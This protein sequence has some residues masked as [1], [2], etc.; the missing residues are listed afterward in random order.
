[1]AD[2]PDL[3]TSGGGLTDFPHLPAADLLHLEQQC[4][5]FESAWQSGSVPRLEDFITSVAPHRRAH[6]LRELLFLEREYRRRRGENPTREEY[7]ARFPGDRAA[8]DEVF[9]TAMPPLAESATRTTG[10]R[11]A[12]DDASAFPPIPGFKIL[13]LL[14]RGG[15]GIVYRAHEESLQR[16]V[17]LKM[18]RGGAQAGLEDLLRFRIE[19]EMVA[20]LQ[21]PDIVQ[22]FEVGE[23]QGQPFLALEFVEGG[24]LKQ[25][26]QRGPLPVSEAALLIEQVAQ[27]VHHAHQ[28]GVVHRDLKPANILLT[29]DNRPKITDFGLAKWLGE[30]KE[31]TQ[32]GTII[33]TPNYMAPEQAEGNARRVGPACDVY[34]LGAVLYELLG[35]KPPFAES[36]T[37]EAMVRLVTEDA[38]S[39]VRVRPNLPRDLVTI[40]ERCMEREPGRR[41]ATAEALADDLGR[42]RRG[43]PIAARPVGLFERSWKWA[44]RRPAVAALSFTAVALALLGGA[45][46]LWQWHDALAARDRA[47][48]G[49]SDAL[50]ARDDAQH[51]TK[52]ALKAQAETERALQQAEAQLYLSHIAQARL[53]ISNSNSATAEMLLDQCPT[54]RRG[55]EW[56]YLRGQLHS[57]L[58][59]I[60]AHDGG[61]SAVSYS[62][63]GK[64]LVSAF[65]DIKIWDAD[66]GKLL[67]TLPSFDSVVRGLSFR[68]PDGKYLAAGYTN[69]ALRIWET[70][71]G[72]LVQ[73]IAA[74]DPSS[75]AAGIAF[76]PG[77]T[78][79]AVGSAD[80]T[81]RIMDVLTHQ[82]ARPSMRHAGPINGVAVRFDGRQLASC[83]M[84]G[85]RVWDLDSGRQVQF[86]PYRA[87]GVFYSPDGSVL[88]LVHGQVAKLWNVASGQ[89]LHTFGG[90]AGNISGAGFSPDG[91]TF[92]TAGVDSLISL[93]NSRS[94]ELQGTRVGHKGPVT[95][96]AFHPSGRVLATGDSNRGELKLWDL[97]RRPD[98]SRASHFDARFDLPPA[99]LVSLTFDA[100]ST[101]V[102]AARS[103]GQVQIREARTGVLRREQVLGVEEPFLY[104]AAVA[105]FSEAGKRV[106]ILDRLPSPRVRVWEIGTEKPILESSRRPDVFSRQLTL[107]R[108]GRYI[109]VVEEDV[110]RNRWVQVRRVDS[111]SVTQS[112]P[113]GTRRADVNDHPGPVLS[114]DGQWLAAEVLD[115][116]PR[117][118]VWDVAV[119][120]ERWSVPLPG[121]LA[122]ATC[123]HDGRL[124]TVAERDG[125]IHVWH[126][127]TGKPYGAFPIVGLPG[128]RALAISHDQRRVAVHGGGRLGL[129]DLH[130]GQEVLNFDS[131][132]RHHAGEWAYE[133]MLAWSP[134][135]ERLAASDY[136]RNVLVFDAADVESPEA[137]ARL[138][139]GAEARAFAWHVARAESCLDWMLRVPGLQSHA[140][141]L[142]AQTPPDLP[143]QWE[144]AFLQ[145]R[146]GNWG[147]VAAHLGD[148][149]NLRPRTQMLQ[150][151]ALLQAGNVTAYRDSCR[152]LRK[153]AGIDRETRAELLLISLLAPEASDAK[154][155]LELARTLHGAH[156]AND[157]FGEHLLALANFRA[158]KSDEAIKLIEA[159]E[160]DHPTWNRRPLNGLLRAA[161]YQR[162]G[163]A[164]K[165]L[166]LRAQAEMALGATSGRLP[167][168]APARWTWSDWLE[169]HWLH[170]EGA[171]VR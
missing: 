13:D 18:V 139:R 49:E 96:C 20:R 158:G 65:L 132:F 50:D 102:V 54:A 10:R 93:W 110:K 162:M 136:Y 167:A 83:G 90:H 41:Y 2:T 145:A 104:T 78:L 25:R 143:L 71:S 164:A 121:R 6:L 23:Y 22:I 168:E 64:W 72:K 131:I 81:V 113:L 73:T 47:A 38:P 170:V 108:N 135:G 5:Q 14:G 1:M 114:P 127:D 155:L 129:L 45:G 133:P 39:L 88:G 94:G 15:M 97:T 68:V 26:L 128:V 154:A 123:S 148:Q 95:H 130:S 165:S 89:E 151:C 80:Q 48:R 140:R 153:S 58:Q 152:R 51:K 44:R 82:E 4:W 3:G 119:G 43:E 106:A 120:R 56:G 77:T 67:R 61:L 52:L 59:T 107:S 160:K 99:D 122:T 86:F 116:P 149:Q 21:H 28:Q 125:R 7:A 60:R 91:F 70:E 12:N 33:G 9:A 112:F 146:R 30:D 84:D 37:V 40:C 46:I 138:R 115:T 92:V 42:Y 69:G 141:I 100:E 161:I 79:L 85:T 157:P 126:A 17:A 118:A 8:I 144:L 31:L 76:V 156:A 63:D 55:W 171:P 34:A 75:P 150:A 109:A 124:L 57:D 163:N 19:G 16:T 147:R 24:S 53:Q 117:L 27:A 101:S 66:T 98:I 35:G 142:E 111:G 29:T 74:R 36:H 137:K 11:A 62:V 166:E 32:S 169:A 134:D 103:G 87:Y 105:A 159:V